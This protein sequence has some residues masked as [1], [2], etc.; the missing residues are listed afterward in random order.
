M[1]YA[2]TAAEFEAAV[3]EAIDDIPDELFDLLDNCAIMVEDDP[4]ADDPELFGLYEGIPLTERG[5]TYAGYLP[6]RIRIFRNPILEACHTRDEVLDE[7]Y[8]TVVHEVAHFFG[9]DDERL[10]ELG[11]A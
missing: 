2:M 6:D 8:I 3:A 4:P 11:W 10:H 1:P 9:I 7:V 5:T